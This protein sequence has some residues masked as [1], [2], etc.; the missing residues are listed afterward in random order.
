MEKKL[1]AKGQVTISTLEDAYHISQTLGEYVFPTLPNGTVASA[2]TVSSTIQV[3]QANTELTDFTI[4]DI[5]K[6]VGFGV[7]TVDNIKKIITYSIAANTTTLPDHG[8]LIIP[9]LVRGMTYN[10]SF[11]WAKAKSGVTGDNG[12][13]GYTLMSSR[14]GCTIATDNDGCIHTAV[15][16][17]TIIS[18][19]RGTTEIIPVIGNLPVIKGCS[20]SKSGSTVTISFNI[21]MSLA[22]EGVIDIPVSL[23]GIVFNV[24]FNYA[25][26]RS[27]ATGEDANLLDWVNDWNT[28]KTVING[29]AVITP[30]IFSGIKNSDG[31]LTGTAIGRFILSVKDG[32]GKISSETVDGIYGFNKG[33]KTFFIDNDGNSQLGRGE[34]FIKFNVET[35][36]VEFG[37]GVSLNW[38][39]ATYIDKDGIF[40]GTLSANVVNTIRLNASQIVT[41]TLSAD[42]VDTIR[43]NASQIV[44]GTL[45]ANIVDTFRLDAS[46][47]VTGTLSADIVNTF[48][49]DAS[50][51]VTGTLSADIVNSLRLNASQIVTGTLSASHIDV[52]SLKS[53]LI[54]AENIEALTL[55][56]SRG[57]VGG[58][59]IDND[60]IY[61]GTK[62][63]IAG[64]YTDSSGCVTLGSHGLRGF[65]WRLEATGSGSL[66]GGN[67]TWDDSGNVTFGTSVALLW[68][69]P[70]NSIKT[71]LGG[72]DYP[73]LTKIT[74]E[75]IYTGNITATQI[76][77]GTLSADCIG[78]GSIQADKLD[79]ASIKT[80]II[81]TDYING[82]SCT[83][84]QGKVGGWKIEANSLVNDHIALD[85]GNKKIVVYGAN[86][87]IM[88]G[89]RVQLYYSSDNDFGFYA[90]DTLGNCV[91]QLGSANKIAGWVFNTTQIYK[92][93]VYLGSDGSIVNGTKWQFNNDGS[94]QIAGGN[95]SWNSNGV[96]T[97]SSTVSLNW[98]NAANNV[99]NAAKSYA[100]SKKVEAINSAASDATNKSNYAR[101]LA[102]AMAFGKMLYRDPT[103][104]I[105]NNG[106]AVYNN[107]HN[108]TVSITRQ[109]DLTAPNDSKYILSI[110]TVGD[111]SPYCGGFCFNTM[112]SYR[113][114]FITRII[115][116]IPLG[117]NLSFHT[118][119]YGTDGM[120]R[121]LTH[122][123]GLGDWCEYILKVGC[124]TS[125]FS[126][127]NYFTVTGDAGTASKPVEWSLAYATVFD[128]TSTERYPTTIN[129][130]GIYTASLNANQITAGTINADRIA[131]NSL[132]GN[133]IISRS[134]T[135]D[136]IVSSAITSNE[137]ATRT[138]TASKIATGTITANEIN[139]NSIQASVVT[140]AAVNGLTCDFKKGKV[141]GFVLDDYALF[142]VNVSAGHSIGI[143]NDGYFFN[144]NS[145]T[146]VN[147][148]AFNPDGSALFGTGKIKFYADGSGYVA[149]QNIKWDTI[150]NV[151]MNGTITATSGKI[152]GFTISG[153]KLLNT[154]AD[155]S[156]EFS[157]MIGNASLSINTSTALISMRA[158]SSRTGISIQTYATGARGL[159]IVA[160][161][162]S[163]YA[164]ES[165]GPTQLG[166]RFNERWCVPGVLYIGSKYSTGY[167]NSYR[168]IWGEGLTISSFSH[169]GDGKYKVVHNLNHT[170]YTVMAILWS[171]TTLYGFFRLL[172]KTDTYF[173]I[174]NVG[175]TG[176]PDQGAFDFTIMGRNVW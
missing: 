13:D 130:D 176:K 38:I 40:T 98:T 85:N 139:V 132:N 104:F 60:S 100:D 95:I 79:A 83:F 61:R 174:Q 115:A 119:S 120:Y 84:S 126:I 143:Q 149:N 103:F 137:I 43:L 26:V 153:N 134:I 9:V 33:N 106:I 175:T 59:S 144:C 55:N 44:T 87:G 48:R 124:G 102:F 36:K 94:G 24:P 75:G 171:S 20:L 18:A 160:N 17:S 25:K 129:G 159:Y 151:A 46:Q 82:L 161:V 6:P 52:D 81:N 50:Q 51:I 35:G 173:V 93:N 97:F 27:G 14:Q 164:I 32:S 101:D 3:S 8:S 70:I 63:N 116:K 77:T 56:V 157:S 167:N 150:G 73:K 72:T 78:V 112:T 110:K 142:S 57:K 158:D 66:A 114:V 108:G 11:R 12:R 22:E 49:L 168:K 128:T 39:G 5:I 62:N 54:T 89:H 155:S 146:L 74:A 123:M 80:S 53:V 107:L 122:T 109:Q 88:S 42:I 31:T 154:A 117:R 64:T 65:K 41:G 111:A 163:K 99:L 140:A 19:L 23:D 165:Y 21:G 37:S 156:I 68:S 76:S 58:W 67:I 15:T 166:Q 86:S 133:K 138:I 69:A 145:S 92:N 90:T 152:A 45:S 135:A 2:I 30:K 148:W 136:R 131:A 113:K 29:V 169:I 172:E 170:D 16:V 162:G 7:I 96:I 127:T 4:G 147:Y 141:G 125:N 47:I 71:A 10:L 34:E 118:N 105:G 28:N 1:V 91:A 121:W